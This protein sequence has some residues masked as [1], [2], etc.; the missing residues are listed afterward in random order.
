MASIEALWQKFLLEGGEPTGIAFGVFLIQH[1]PN[2]N[3]SNDNQFIITNQPAQLTDNTNHLPTESMAGIL[4]G[5]LERFLFLQ[6]KP[7]LKKAGLQNPD[8]FSVLATLFF[9]NGITK[10]QLLK[11]A[12][13][14]PATGSEMLKRMHRLG[15]LDEQPHPTDGRATCLLLTPAGQQLVERCFADLSLVEGLMDGLLPSEKTTL[16]RLLDKLE[17][18]HSKQNGVLQVTAWMQETDKYH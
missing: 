12:L 5:R 3:L 4:L 16:L 11:Q 7:I 6:T 14:E 17:H 9:K 10:S 13:I 2:I 1:A 8:D 18:H 15:W